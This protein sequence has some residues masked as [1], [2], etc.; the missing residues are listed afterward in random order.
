MHRSGGCT[1]YARPCEAGITVHFVVV[2]DFV[3]SFGTLL[4]LGLPQFLLFAFTNVAALF[5]HQLLVA[6]MNL[7][8]RVPHSAPDHHD[9]N[10]KNWDRFDEDSFCKHCGRTVADQRP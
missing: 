1:D 9:G 7:S 3:E 2:G 5:Q 4:F 10:D 8:C 6:R